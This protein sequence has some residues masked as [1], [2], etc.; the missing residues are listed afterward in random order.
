MREVI[1]VTTILAVLF[2]PLYAFGDTLTFDAP[3]DF[4]SDFIQTEGSVDDLVETDSIGV[5]GTRAIS[6]AGGD[7][8][9]LYVRTS[10]AGAASS[11]FSASLRFDYDSNSTGTGGVPLVFGF[12][13][14]SSFVGTDSGNP[15]DDFIGVEL[16]QRL[17]GSNESSV[18]VL[19]GS[20]GVVEESAASAFENLLPTFYEIE[21]IVEFVDGSIDISAALHEYNADGSTVEASEVVTVAISSLDN[22]QVFYASNLYLYVGG[23]D[24]A[25]RGI[26]ALDNFSFNDL[27]ISNAISIDT[28]TDLVAVT[29]S[30]SEAGIT[31]VDNSNN[32]EGFRLDRRIEGGEWD[33]LTIL[34]PNVTMFSDYSIVGMTKYY[35]RTVAFNSGSFSDY[36]FS[37][38]SIDTPTNL[39]AVTVS[40]SV[41]ELTWEDNS[42]NEEGFQLDRRI[43]GGEWNILT[44]LDPNVSMFTDG[45]IVAGAAYEYRIVAFSSGWFSDYVFS[46]IAIN[47]PTDVVA[48]AVTDSE[49][50]ITW[51]D[52]SNNEAGFRLDRRIAGGEWD[53]LTIVDANVGMFID[54]NVV[55]KTTYE[56]RI[57]AF[58]SG[59][60]SDLSS[61]STIT[62]P[63]EVG[64]IKSLSNRAFV[65]T[66]DDVLI[67]SFRIKDNDLRIYIVVRGPSLAAAGIANPLMDP[68]LRLIKVGGANQEE[69]GERIS[70]NWK[71]DQQAEIE[72][73]FADFP[74][75]IPTFDSESAMLYTLEK[76]I[77]SAVVRGVG[78]STGFANIEIYERKDPEFLRPG[79][80]TSLSNRALVGTG[81]DILIGS[82]S[83]TGTTPRDIY[84]KI[85]G[86][87]LV[88]FSNPL[89]DPVLRIVQVGGPGKDSFEEII[90]DDWKDN[91]QQSVIEAK[92]SDKTFFIPSNDAEPARLITGLTR[93]SY[94]AII[95][96]AGGTT[97]FANV[98][99]Y[100]V[101]P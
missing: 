66:G 11:S 68:T 54:Y 30:N 97:G 3:D 14:N 34:N 75:F 18:K 12:T 53:M 2:S 15:M 29:V 40:D 72:S 36:V 42:D 94:S 88:G 5:N 82:F 79:N 63:G 25:N 10:S 21:L 74:A 69:F 55:G 81:N 76:G 31:W 26:L 13:S 90:V 83:I 19:S 6:Y 20:K 100:D 39:A 77:Y 71:S 8:K 86:P 41:A 44:I 4:I 47:A 46:E 80:L 60:F 87:S 1:G 49:A 70:D 96:G 59:W 43:V 95:S 92:F 45:S 24:L 52:N 37:E 64:R 93:G 38:I 89:V 27:V 22:D 99:I 33:I 78:G 35:Y 85:V 32:E 58:V 61:T 67:G 101:T 62:T 17:T 98:E 91:G 51:A 84:L 56:Y 28:P 57:V 73:V 65:G 7:W 50:N 9:T 48:V 16:S 23:T